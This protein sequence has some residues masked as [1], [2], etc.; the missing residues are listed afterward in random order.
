M[1]LKDFIER[2]IL[3]IEYKNNNND[4]RQWDEK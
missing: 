3:K 4:D 2:Q 1:M